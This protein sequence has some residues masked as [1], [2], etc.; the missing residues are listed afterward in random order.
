M[1]V[2]L[3]PVDYVAAAIITLFLQERAA[4]RVFN[5]PAP[6]LVHWR[7]FVPMVNEF[8]YSIEVMSYVDW[9]DFMMGSGVD[10][11]KNALFPFLPLIA[12]GGRDGSNLPF[13]A[14]SPKY[15][16]ENTRHGLAGT[17]IACAPLDRRLLETYLRYLI[18]VQFLP[19]PTPT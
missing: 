13:M 17:G 9:Y 10:I 8:G 18:D 14:G 6:H 1:M 11:S 12:E 16:E 3:I 5:L 7:D 2:E 19:A 4:G 15:V